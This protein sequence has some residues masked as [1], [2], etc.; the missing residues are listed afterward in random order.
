MVTA[1]DVLAASVEAAQE[2]WIA[3]VA[4][5]PHVSDP[6]FESVIDEPAV[7]AL[8]VTADA[9]VEILLVDV[10]MAPVPDDTVRAPEVDILVD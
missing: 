3:P 6:V 1:A 4:V 7:V 2:T 10:P 9:L 8:T 5:P